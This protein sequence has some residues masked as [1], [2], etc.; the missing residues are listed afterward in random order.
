MFPARNSRFRGTKPHDYGNH[1]QVYHQCRE[2]GALGRAAEQL[3]NWQQRSTGSRDGE[4]KGGRNREGRPP[5]LLRL[6]RRHREE[7]NIKREEEGK[8]GGKRVVVER[9]E[10]G[11]GGG[12]ETPAGPDLADHRSRRPPL[13][14][15][16]AAHAPPCARLAS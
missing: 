14:P 5:L 13:A 1:L 4:R 11:S 12:M 9:E 2:R 10:E 16:S 3:V 15:S 7:R 6:C 8:E